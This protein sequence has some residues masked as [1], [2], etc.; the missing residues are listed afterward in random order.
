MVLNKKGQSNSVL[1]SILLG[2]FGVLVLALVLLAGFHAWD[3][4]YAVDTISN[5][6]TQ[7]LSPVFGSLLNLDNAGENAFL[8]V[9]AFILMV[10]IIT[11]TFDSVDIFSSQGTG[12]KWIN[13]AIG[14]IVSIIGVRFMPSD[15]WGSLT[16]PSSALVATIL[17]GIPF[18][19]LFFV[20]M[21]LKGGLVRKLL[22]AFYII[23]MSYLIF[24]P[25]ASTTGFK[26]VYVVFLVLAGFIMFFDASV[27]NLFFRE[28]ASVEMANMIGKMNV[29]QRYKLRKAIA[30]YNE[31]LGDENSPA[32][33]VATAKSQIKKLETLYGDLSQI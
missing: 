30:G 20:T 22:W 6:I 25:G 4:S 5:F 19:A 16:A 27:R 26:W 23:F 17:V 32:A 28:K 21:K 1:S 2:G 29:T 24:K 12:G 10:I 3:F 33:D 13:F 31:V 14:V 9:L 11:G 15:I 7:V 8:M 18:G